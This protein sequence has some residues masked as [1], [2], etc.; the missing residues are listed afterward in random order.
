[1]T[2]T[3]NQTLQI[4]LTAHQEGRLKEA[5]RLYRFILEGNPELP[6]IHNNLAIIL[7]TRGKL[8]EAIVSYKKAIELKPD[9]AEA[10]NSLGQT[11][12]RVNKIEE[13]EGIFIRA[14]ELNPGSAEAHN[15]LGNIFR[16]LNK[17]EEAKA[18]YKK[19]I[20][21]SP[22]LAEAHN[23][24]GVILKKLNKID[25]SEAS[26]N[27]AIEINPN[28]QDALKNRGQI[29]FKKGKFELSLRDFDNC[30]NKFSKSKSLE[31]LY[32]LGRIDE[33][34]KRIEIDSKLD[35]QNLNI[36]AFSSFISYKKKKVTKN[37]FCNNPMD[38]IKISNISSHLKDSNLFIREVIDELKNI[39]TYWDPLDRTTHNG[40]HSGNKNNLFRNPQKKMN[41]LKSIILDEL[42]L[43][44]SK[45][46]DETCSFIK[47]WPT[48]KN[49]MCWYIILKKQGY[50]ISHIH[51]TGWL[52]GVI[53]LKVVPS[54]EKNEGA[55]EFSLNGGNFHDEDS[56]KITHQ[57]NDGDIVLFPSSLHHRTIP[58]TT[59][60]DRIIVSFDLLVK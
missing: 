48:E 45:F 44:K 59:D 33:I 29:L 4:A 14:T 12:Y 7:D 46:K 19:A 30:N 47:R 42:D 43:Y 55:I 1:M 35:D 16:A 53:Y 41:N 20:E 60:T 24:L 5:E 39:K 38:F 23:N 50:Q 25:E 15:N 49:L 3:T 8:E 37:K 27:K 56:P 18:S 36:A 11:L 22:E 57:P 32:A 40:Y 6:N 28:Y 52:S 54:L 21:I 31:C 13:S 34:Y 58:F 51:P 17:D 9:Y 2:L 26:Y 10:Y